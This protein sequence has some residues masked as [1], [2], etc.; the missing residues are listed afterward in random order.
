MPGTGEYQ[1]DE[2]LLERADALAF[3]LLKVGL[4][5]SARPVERATDQLTR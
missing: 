3:L 4:A 5:I 1:S 2:A